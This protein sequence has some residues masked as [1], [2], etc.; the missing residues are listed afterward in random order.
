MQK[1]NHSALVLSGGGARGA[2]QAG[3]VLGLSEI[4]GKDFPFDILTGVSAGGINTAYLA[5]YRDDPVSAARQLVEI[6]KNLHTT[7]VFRSDL[8]SL[9]RIAIRWIIDLGFGGLLH[10]RKNL[11]QCLLDTSPLHELISKSLPFD[12]IEKNIADNYLHSVAVTA[13]EYRESNA[14]TF[15][16]SNSKTSGWVRKKR[17]SV[18]TKLA[19][20][21][22]MASSAIPILFPPISIQSTYY[23]DGS[24]R[25]M[26]PLSPA[27]HLG[28]N[29]LLIVSVK[30]PAKVASSHLD[31]KNQPSTARVLSVVLNA[32]LLD[33]LDFDMERLE[34]INQAVHMISSEYQNQT[35]LRPID[36]VWIQPSEDIGEKAKEYAHLLPATIRY[37]I[38]GLGSIEQASEIISY[39]L[40]APPFCSWLVDL[41]YR[42]A[43]NRSDEIKKL[44]GLM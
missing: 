20:E 38:R 41:G 28:A 27:I 22:I 16:E 2:Y 4:F 10:R 13:T 36:Y 40:F 44:W 5:A 7:Q 9:A 32:I 17:M 42:D 6:W 21:H 15:V 25:N 24:L 43:Q 11:A 33:Q 3:V 23:G 26:A 35:D 14:I 1:K 29:K 12:R 34:R 39:L 30:K 31:G 37:L 8:Y 18:E 19:V